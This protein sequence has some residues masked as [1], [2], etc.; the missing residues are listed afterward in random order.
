MLPE[1]D[2]VD[3]RLRELAK[4]RQ[5]SPNVWADAYLAAFSSAAGLKL[6]TFDKA[7]RSRAVEC[8]VLE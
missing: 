4:S 8:L 5:V 1:P 6:V 2:G 7:L 3:P